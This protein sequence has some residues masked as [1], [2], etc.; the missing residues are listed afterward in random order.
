M[1]FNA[2]IASST[3]VPVLLSKSCNYSLKVLGE[4]DIFTEMTVTTNMF[5]IV[6]FHKS[7]HFW[8]SIL[9]PR[10]LENPNFLL[11]GLRRGGVCMPKFE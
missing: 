9:R 10:T 1:S 4:F 2:L 7:D 6:E 5:E 8:L 11:R 3:L